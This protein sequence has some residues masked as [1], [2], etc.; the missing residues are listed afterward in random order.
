MRPANGDYVHLRSAYAMLSRETLL[1]SPELMK[2]MCMIESLLGHQ[3]ESENWYQELKHFAQVTPEQDARRHK[4]EESLAYLDI[5]LAHRG[6]GSL[7]KT[8]LSFSQMTRLL[9]SGSWK[10]GFNAAGN[11]VSLLNGGK[12]FCRWVP[13]G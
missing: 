11:S 3:Q 4:A 9:Q 6:S 5:A 13:H 1:A 10:D 8:L 7:L 12:D 2:G